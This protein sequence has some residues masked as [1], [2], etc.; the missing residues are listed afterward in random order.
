VKAREPPG[1][2]LRVFCTLFRRDLGM[3]FRHPAIYLIVGL[4]WLAL[5]WFSHNFL[6]SLGKLG[7]S[8]AADPVRIPYVVS[9]VLIAFY[10]AVASGMSL[11]Q[12]RENRTLEVFFYGPA[13]PAA[14]VF[15]LFLRDASVFLVCA[16]S[17]LAAAFAAGGVTKLFP[18]AYTLR[19]VGLSIL[20]VWPTLGLSLLASAAAR[21]TRTA[22]ILVVGV[23]LIFAALQAAGILLGALPAEGLSLAALVARGSLLALLRVLE[24]LSPLGYLA[25]VN[26][27]ILASSTLATAGVLAAAAGYTALMLVLATLVLARRELGA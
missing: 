11:A 13:T 10:L 23:F 24:W 17:F 20:L 21:R 26:D 9:V 8:V 1:A 5:A 2:R 25:H 16:A 12:E 14:R 22:V 27:A 4:V 15:S 7:V 18:G 6:F 3:V 19:S